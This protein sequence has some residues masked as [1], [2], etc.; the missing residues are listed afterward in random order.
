LQKSRIETAARS[1]VRWSC[2]D[3]RSGHDVSGVDTMIGMWVV[4]L[5]TDLLP[6]GAKVQFTVYWPDSGRWERTN[7]S[8]S[9]GRSQ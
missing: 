2:D 6:T 1:V 8:V 9:I 7:F 5:A 3:W 4:D